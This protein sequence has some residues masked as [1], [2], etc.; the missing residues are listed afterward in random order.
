M[1]NIKPFCNIYYK[2]CYYNSLFTVLRYFDKDNI[3]FLSKEIDSFIFKNQKFKLINKKIIEED[4]IEKRYGITKKKKCICKEKII[5]FIA[6]KR[7]KNQFI[8]LETDCYFLPHRKDCYLKH[9]MFHDTLVCS[10]D[11]KFV[12]ILD[13][14]T[15]DSLDYSIKA[16][17]KKDFLKS[18]FGEEKEEK[19]KYVHIFSLNNR[20]SNIKYSKVILKYLENQK[21]YFKKNQSADFIKYE[22]EKLE[23]LNSEKKL[24]NLLTRLNKIINIYQIESELYKTIIKE[25]K[26]K[27]KKK[28]KEKIIELLNIKNEIIE[29]FNFFRK[30]II[31]ISLKFNIQS[32]KIK[33]Y[34]NLVLLEILETKYLELILKI[35]SLR[36]KDEK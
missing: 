33:F 3:L 18:I 29:V 30:I 1:E 21:K 31:K 12:Y 7:I 34:K 17:L 16:V 9:H 20:N 8:I 4:K 5:E 32:D 14:T 11:L 13:H 15:K 26:L 23:K 10:V 2:D 22:F 36:G 35:L 25:K 6:K 24:N 19:P 28:L 27:I